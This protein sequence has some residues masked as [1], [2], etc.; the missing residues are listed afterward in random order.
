[1]VTSNNGQ[2]RCGNGSGL[3]GPVIYGTGSQITLTG[4]GGWTI[5]SAVAGRLATLIRLR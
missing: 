4:T 2:I 3:C 5:Y 1:M